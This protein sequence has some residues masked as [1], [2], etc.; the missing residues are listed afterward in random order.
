MK[1]SNTN[2]QTASITTAGPV[3]SYLDNESMIVLLPQ[4]PAETR[5]YTSQC[6][7]TGVHAEVHVAFVKL[8]NALAPASVAC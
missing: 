6:G 7:R 4:E 3:V 8:L 2:Q 1:H 5:L